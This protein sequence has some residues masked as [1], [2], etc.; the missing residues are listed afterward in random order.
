[1]D[2]KLL[3]L[4]H[5]KSKQNRFPGFDEI[6]FGARNRPISEIAVAFEESDQIVTETEAE[7]L[8]I[9][10]E[11]PMFQRGDAAQMK[12]IYENV[13][14]PEETAG[15]NIEGRVIIKFVVATDGSVKRDEV[16]RGVHPSLNSEAIRVITVM[17]AWK[18]GKQ[19]GNPASVWYNVPV[20]FEVRRN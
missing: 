6:V 16:L 5:L 13:K 11:P 12:F 17:P 9:A 4:F 7:P 3:R 10:R 1:M 15:N 2:V 20:K 8:I 19:N 18:P 14:Y